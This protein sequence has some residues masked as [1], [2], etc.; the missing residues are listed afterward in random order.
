MSTFESQVSK[1]EIIETQIEHTRLSFLDWQSSDQNLS[2]RDNDRKSSE[3]NNRKLILK[4]RHG[5]LRL[6][7]EIVLSKMT[8]CELEELGPWG[9]GLVSTLPTISMNVKVYQHGQNHI[10]GSATGSDVTR[11]VLTG[12]N[13]NHVTR[14]DMTGSEGSRPFS[15]SCAFFLLG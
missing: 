10:W 6:Q 3:Q 2:S 4:W 14:S 12:N 1:R 11:R 8:F 5:I 7:R 9:P 15:V 13:V